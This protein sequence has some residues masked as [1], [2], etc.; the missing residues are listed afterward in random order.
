MTH[1]IGYPRVGTDPRT[2]GFLHLGEKKEGGKIFVVAAKMSIL[3]SHV[4]MAF[5]KKNKRVDFF[6]LYF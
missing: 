5:T 1:S 2:S 4:V 6:L 3:V